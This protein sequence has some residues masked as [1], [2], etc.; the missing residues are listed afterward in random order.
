MLFNVLVQILAFG[1]GAAHG[2]IFFRRHTQVI[3]H[4]PGY[5]YY[6]QGGFISIVFHG[7]NNGGWHIQQ[8]WYLFIPSKMGPCRGEYK[9][10]TRRWQLLPARS[11]VRSNTFIEDFAGY[12]QRLH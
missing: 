10:N 11:F 1:A 4:H 5:K 9:R 3:V 8:D 6:P 2:L 7:G 12:L